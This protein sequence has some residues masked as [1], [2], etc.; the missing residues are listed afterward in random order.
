[1]DM[2]MGGKRVKL[3]LCLINYASHHEDMGEWRY[4]SIIP[5]LRIRWR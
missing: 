1:M 4:S 5:D 2:F 3:S